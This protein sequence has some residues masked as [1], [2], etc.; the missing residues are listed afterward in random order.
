[1]RAKR[2]S[3]TVET[4][5]ADSLKGRALSSEFSAPLGL[6]GAT[7]NVTPY[8]RKMAFVGN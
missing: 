1:M 2:A 5:I 3:S 8:S 7:G 6:S 4:G